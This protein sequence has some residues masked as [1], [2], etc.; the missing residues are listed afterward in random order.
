MADKDYYEVLGV[1]RDA[2]DSE[3]KKAFRHKAR[4]LHPDVNKAPDA[5]ERFKEVNEAY[6]VLSDPKKKQQYDRFGTVD[7][8]AGGFQSVD[9]DDIF[10]SGFGMG[11][12][13]SSFFGGGG[14]AQARREGR[15]MGVGIKL[16]LEEVAAGVAKE[17][18]YDRLAPCEECGGTGAA[19][20]GKN[21]ECPSCHGTG[22]V[23][24][25]QRTLLGD[26]RTTSTCPDCH[27]VGT[28]VDTPCPE[29]DGQG[30]VPDRTRVTVEVPRGIRDG[31]QLRLTGYGEAGMNGA[32]PGNL[33]VT[34]RIEE[35]KYFQRDGDN[36]HTAA[37][38][39]I[40]QASLG[41][42][43]RISGILP[44]E[45]IDVHVPEGCQNDQVVRIKGK[46]MPRFRNDSRGDLY[47]HMRV[48]VPRNLTKRQRELL[49]Q[50][51]A[52]LGEDVS[53]KRT[54]LQALKD[55]FNG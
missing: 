1:S 27:G 35:H 14:R 42:D 36:L 29:C 34:V 43:I 53:E 2:T 28:I 47:V 10:G 7:P 52:E 11:D 44:D 9:F 39:S 33:I 45:Q 23:T 26:M 25:V 12:L 46:G 20:G 15:D 31:Q 19:K 48:V 5:E 21:V 24:T 54:P 37:T 51:A 55:V 38:V 30:R 4:E 8:G 13:F 50:L 6:D 3:I 22:T 40:A 49:E 32:A 18:V 17:I 16:T 41:A